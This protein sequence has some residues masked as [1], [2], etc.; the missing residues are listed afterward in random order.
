MDNASTRARSKNYVSPLRE[1]QAQRT[2]EYI[3]EALAEHLSE[4]GWETPSFARVAERA[5]VSEPTV[6]RH[7]PNRDAMFV[8]LFDWL[9]ARLS[10]PALPSSIDEVPA[11]AHALFDHFHE[12][13]GIVRAGLHS[14]IGRAMRERARKKRDAASLA[15]FVSEFEHLQ[16]EEARAAASVLRVLLSADAWGVMTQRIGIEPAAASAAVA[17]ATAALIDTARRD[18]KRGRKTLTSPETVA[19]ARAMREQRRPKTAGKRR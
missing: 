1:E 15:M 2:R 14:S 17:W 18:A 12:H 11:R 4:E 13:A 7:F 8:A 16:P 9:D 10:F 3:L 19:A 5:G 6:Y